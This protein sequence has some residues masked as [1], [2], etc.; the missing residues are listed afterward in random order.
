MLCVSITYAIYKKQLKMKLPDNF[1]NPQ[2]QEKSKNLNM[3]FLS[4]NV[5]IELSELGKETNLHA[6]TYTDRLLY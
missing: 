4:D 2:S 3:E 6:K 1:L 5:K